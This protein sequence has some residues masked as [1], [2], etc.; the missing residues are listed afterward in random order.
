MHNTLSSLVT[1]AAQAQSAAASAYSSLLQSDQL[2][3][4]PVYLPR[5]TQLLKSLD[6]SKEATL[7][8]VRARTNLVRSLET[9]LDRQKSELAKAQGLLSEVDEQVKSVKVTRDEVQ[10]MV[11]G[12]NNVRST[13]PDVEPPEVEGLTPPAIAEDG[14]ESSEIDKA[15]LDD[16]VGLENL[17]PEII[18]L[19]KADM[20]LNQSASLNTNNYTAGNADD[21]YAP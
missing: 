15:R 1:Y 8:V 7:A 9:L 13:T 18:A 19:L 14:L 12:D 16:L 10:N 3:S 21:G 6:T 4:P 5:L 20:G 2:P 17:D 11:G